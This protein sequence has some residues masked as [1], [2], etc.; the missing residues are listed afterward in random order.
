MFFVLRIKVGWSKYLGHTLTKEEYLNLSP[1]PVIPIM[2]FMGK[3]RPK[4]VPFIGFRY[5]KG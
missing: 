5:I 2:V 3:L 4:V 1:P